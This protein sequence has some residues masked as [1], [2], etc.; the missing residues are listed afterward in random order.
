MCLSSCGYEGNQLNEQKPSISAFKNAF[1]RKNGPQP[2]L[3]PFPFGEAVFSWQKF[4]P[5][6]PDLIGNL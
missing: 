1:W 2:L 4:N 6:I 5:V 3:P